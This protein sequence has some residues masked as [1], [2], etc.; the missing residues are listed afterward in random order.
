MA[1]KIEQATTSASD[2]N[3][4]ISKWQPYWDEKYK[5]YYWSDGNESV[6]FS[7]HHFFFHLKFYFRYG[8]HQKVV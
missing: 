3:E 1:D 8:K 6:I 5:R 7:F 4:D 2:T